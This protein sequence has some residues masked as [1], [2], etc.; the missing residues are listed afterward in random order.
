[1]KRNSLR[2]DKFNTLINSV[3]GRQSQN[4]LSSYDNFHNNNNINNLSTNTANVN[5]YFDIRNRKGKG[6]GGSS[7]QKSE[8][9]ETN[10]EFQNHY[11]E[12]LQKL[13]KYF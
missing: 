9:N 11:K 3:K 4:L 10:I 8:I 13:S 5:N 6:T 12:I 2:I 1:M 7:N